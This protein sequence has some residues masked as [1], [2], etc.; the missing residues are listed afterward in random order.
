VAI[1]V[2]EFRSMYR[3][4]SR[5]PRP[6]GFR[7]SAASALQRLPHADRWAIATGLAGHAEDAD[8]ANLPLMTWYGIEPLVKTDLPRSLKLAG[9]A[10]IPLLRQFISRRAAGSE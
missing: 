2:Q 5:R 10:K 4:A 3:N 6:A 9:E 1:K 7:A 8:D